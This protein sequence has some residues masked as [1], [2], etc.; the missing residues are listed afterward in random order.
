[1]SSVVAVLIV[2]DHPIFRKGLRALLANHPELRLAGEATSGVEAVRL[3]AELCPDLIL[4]DLQMPGGD[5]ISAIRQIMTAQPASRILVVTMFDDD[6]SVFAAMRAGARGYVLKDTADTEL[7]RALLAVGHGEAIFSPAIAG[8]MMRFFEQRSVA[9][10]PPFPEL[11]E[12]ER[13]VLQLIA[14]GENNQAIAERLALSPKTVR[15][16][17]SNIFSKLQVADR[18]QAIV[19]ARDAGLGG[20]TGP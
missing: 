7:S 5:G 18:A 4:M 20:A 14:Q 9:T 16:Y 8:R 19:R 6:E 12:S 2:D 1:M 3:S 13:R 11:S 17:I 15:N 10:P